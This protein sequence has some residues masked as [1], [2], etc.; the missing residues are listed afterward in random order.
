MQ[1]VNCVMIGAKCE[2]ANLPIVELA[3]QKAAIQDELL[4]DMTIS[5]GRGSKPHDGGVFHRPDFHRF[6]PWSPHPELVV[7]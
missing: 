4:R 5:T 3:C 6:P 7:G 1:Q 2:C